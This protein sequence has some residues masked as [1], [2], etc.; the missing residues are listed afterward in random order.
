MA[1]RFTG[2][3]L[4]EK[5][6]D[7]FCNNLL[8]SLAIFN[9]VE[10]LAADIWQKRK[11]V[12]CWEE[13][14][15]VTVWPQQEQVNQM[16]T[17]KKGHEY[18]H[19]DQLS[20]VLG[21]FFLGH[22]RKV[23]LKQQGRNSVLHAVLSLHSWGGEGAHPWLLYLWAC[24]FSDEASCAAVYSLSLYSFSHSCGMKHYSHRWN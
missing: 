2:W 21:V 22:D 4:Q 16:G 18:F 12:L 11:V 19:R 23:T 13:E 20:I 9:P 14:T 8:P 1:S 15:E 17:V 3:S 7:E 24:P 10:E 6:V 5:K